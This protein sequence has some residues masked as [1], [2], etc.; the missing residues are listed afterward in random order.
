M[1]QQRG[2]AARFAARLG[3]APQTLNNY[4]TGKSRPGYDFLRL[5]AE[6]A[7][8]DIGWLISGRSLADRGGSAHPSASPLVPI[9]G[10]V[11][12]GPPGGLDWR[13]H[14]AST[15]REDLAA[16]GD[17]DAI[18]LEVLDQ[19]MWPTLF[20][21]DRVVMS[22]GGRWAQGDLVV[23]E[24]QD[25]AQSYEVRRLGACTR[26]EI[27]LIADNFLDFAPVTLP[28][29]RVAVRGV[30]VRV[31]RT[32]SRR[33]P[34]REGDAALM[35]FYRNPLIRQIMALLPALGERAQRAIMRSIRAFADEGL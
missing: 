15:I 29:G 4:L 14:G 32:P 5:L 16:F 25:S 27:T 6:K 18:A 22:P 34:H 1:G 23:A 13:A 19:S 10:R 12:P 8:L 9:L 35:E 17:R 7:E 11:P 33:A 24:I 3:V 30:V 21:K 31:V 26:E 2:D 28:V 20:Q